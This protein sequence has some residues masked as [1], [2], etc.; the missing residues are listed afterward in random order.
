MPRNKRKHPV[1]R[2]ER[3]MLAAI[4]SLPFR[5]NSPGEPNPYKPVPPNTKKYE[6]TEEEHTQRQ[7]EDYQ[8][9]HT[10]TRGFKKQKPNPP[11]QVRGL[12]N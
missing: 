9:T 7:H 1:S 8:T 3:I 4:D 11:K 2:Y 12:M 6:P 5:F 10:S